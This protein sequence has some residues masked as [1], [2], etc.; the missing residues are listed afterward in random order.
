LHEAGA[1]VG[2]RVRFDRPLDRWRRYAPGEMVGLTLFHGA[3]SRHIAVAAWPEAVTFP[4]AFDYGCRAALALLALVFGLLIGLRRPS[5]FASRC[6]ALAFLTL[7]S[8]L[9]YSF[10]YGP[11]GL[12]TSGGKLLQLTLN[13]LIW[14]WCAG[15]VLNYQR[16]Q[17]TPL[18]L[19]LRRAVRYWRPVALLTA[20][21]NG[22]FA[23]GHEVPLLWLLNVACVLGGVLLTVLSLFDGW[24]QCRG[25]PRERH[26]WLLLAFACGTIPPFLTMIPALD[27]APA[28]IRF[29]VMLFFAGQFAMYALLAYAVLRHRVFSFDFAISRAVVFSA[30]SLL[31]LCAFG[32]TEWL[33]GPMLH[34]S[35]GTDAAARRPH[36]LFDAGLA[37]L[38]SLGFNQVH[39]RIEGTI[40]RLL[41]RKWHAREHELRAYLAAATRCTATQPL[42]ESAVAAFECFTGGAGVAVYL[43][44]RG[45]Y[46]L[47]GGHGPAC[48][49]AAIGTDDAL[50]VTL[51]SALKPV[52]PG[53]G[54]AAAGCELALPMCHRNHMNGLVLLGQKPLG[55][56][57]RPDEIALLGFATQQ[58]GLD[59]HALR[60]AA[61]EQDRRRL[62]E[63][64]RR[65]SL[66]LAAAA[67]RRRVADTDLVTTA[68]RTLGAA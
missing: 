68:A 22:W 47:V 20:A 24:R 29:T 62:V 44:Q 5:D 38:V 13:S 31:L 28:G 21:A 46:L 23:L 34:G 42:L 55:E 10:N 26:R 32:L 11:P 61:L 53:A 33:L 40:E 1:L 35:A 30:V 7:T 9:F 67:G 59:L 16:Y 45:E 52:Q 66:D 6:L 27:W 8:A 14:Y 17:S 63:R 64:T 39:A 25:E 56:T 48:Q 57:Y 54:G 65:Q 50:A 2:D 19:V 15:F 58:I 37:V 51:R 18:R 36:P 41:F 49:P 4:D 43:Y 60:V 12:A 3:V